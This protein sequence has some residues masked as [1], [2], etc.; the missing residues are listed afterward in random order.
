LNNCIT[1][2]SLNNALKHAHAQHIT[3]QL[4]QVHTRVVLEISDDGVGFEPS[5]AY[6]NG[7]LGLRGIAERVAQLAGTFTLQS[8]PGAGTQLHVEVLL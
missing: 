7:G 4:R 3:I 1:Q 5:L 8:A 2:E 6:T